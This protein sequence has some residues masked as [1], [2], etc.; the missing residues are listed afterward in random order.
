[1]GFMDRTGLQ[2]SQDN[3]GPTGSTN[4]LIS[5][6]GDILKSCKTSSGWI[7]EGAGCTNTF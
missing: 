1:M 7:I 2:I 5:V 6:G 4:L 3:Y